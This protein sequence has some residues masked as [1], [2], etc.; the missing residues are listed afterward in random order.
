MADTATTIRTRKF[1]TN[2]LLFRKQML[3]DVIHP[4]KAPLSRKDV[5]ERLAKMYKVSDPRTVIVFGF[6]TR[7]GAHK[8]TGF[9]LIYDNLDAVMKFEPVYRLIRQG[10]KK[11]VEKSRKQLK[12]RKNRA[13]KFRGKERAKVLRPTSTK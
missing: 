12:E 10:L 7:F 6:K 9:A 5:Q 11:N 2:R 1:S 3:V 8:S 13:K 4:G